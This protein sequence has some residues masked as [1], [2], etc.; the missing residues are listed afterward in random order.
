MTALDKTWTGL[1]VLKKMSAPGC[2]R[3]LTFKRILGLLKPKRGCGRGGATADG[4]A[5]RT[6]TGDAVGLGGAADIASGVGSGFGDCSS[7]SWHFM[8]S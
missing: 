4:D 1:V 6:G 3:L 7:I 2:E 8:E 5:G